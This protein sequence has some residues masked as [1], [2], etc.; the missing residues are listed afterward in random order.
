[1]PEK[2]IP[3][4]RA[5]ILKRITQGP[6]QFNELAQTKRNGSDARVKARKHCDKLVADGLILLIFIGQYRYYIANTE[7][8]KKAAIRQQIEENSRED[9]E[10]GCTIWTGYVDPMR[11][12]VMRQG[13]ADPNSAVNVR[14]WLF[15]ELI[16]RDLKGYEE[17]VKMKSRCDADCIKEDHMVRK[18]RSQLLRGIPKQL[19]AKLAIQAAMKRRWGKSPDAVEIIR[20]SEKTNTELAKELDMTPSNVWAIRAGRT[21]KLQQSPFA[22][23]GARP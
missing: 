17:S 15:S 10:T 4:T 18:T 14:R 19:P 21:H 5:Q 22:G 20:A 9:K 12:P 16:G 1:M 2:I 7:E 3:F 13:L 8:A 6:T 11:G 23:L